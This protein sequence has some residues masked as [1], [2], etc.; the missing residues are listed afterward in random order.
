M[1]GPP[2]VFSSGMTLSDLEFKIH[3]AAIEKYIGGG[4]LWRSQGQL[5]SIAVV[6]VRENGDLR[7]GEPQG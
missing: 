1:E 4:Q 2:M 5:G 6:Q 7:G 3:V